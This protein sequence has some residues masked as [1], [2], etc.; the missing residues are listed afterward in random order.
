MDRNKL[1]YMKNKINHYF[2]LCLE[3][4]ELGYTHKE[5]IQDVYDVASEAIYDLNEGDNND[6]KD[7]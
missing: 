7:N 1:V 6:H 4:P 5:L 2:E 3:N